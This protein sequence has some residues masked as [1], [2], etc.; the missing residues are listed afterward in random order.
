MQDNKSQFQIKL[1]RLFAYFDVYTEE[2]LAK[3]L[4]TTRAAVSQ[5][6]YKKRLPEKIRIKYH[7]IISGKGETINV[8]NKDI[9][10]I[11]E[12]SKVEMGADYIIELQK[13]KIET[14]AREIKELKTIVNNL[15]PKK[16]PVFHFRSSAEYNADTKTWGKGIVE[17]D[18]SML[19]YTNDELANLSS[20]DWKDLYHPSSQ[21]QLDAS[22][23]SKPVDYQ[24]TKV[25]HMM[26]KAK[27]GS[28]KIFNIEAYYNKKEKKVRTYF[29]WVNGDLNSKN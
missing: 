28:Y 14:Q 2:A 6:K 17:G 1:D 26:M 7:N 27:N 19:G 23:M 18:T 24:H 20:Q 8:K 12:G 16:K 25:D 10:V 21:I 5:W 4:N 3:K 15:K 22:H 13:D 29:Y 9:P 11:K